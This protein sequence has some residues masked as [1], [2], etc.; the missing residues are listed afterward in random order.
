M[1]PFSAIAIVIG[2]AGSLA[3]T[4]KV[5]EEIASRFSTDRFGSNFRDAV[6]TLLSSH[7]DLIAVQ[8]SLQTKGIHA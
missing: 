4:C 3:G 1:E 8:N 7:G 6:T 5:L 2:L